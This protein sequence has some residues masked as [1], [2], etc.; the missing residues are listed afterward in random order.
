MEAINGTAVRHQNP[1][2]AKAL[3]DLETM[4]ANRRSRI[5][6]FEAHPITK[7]LDAII[8]RN[9]CPAPRGGMDGA[10]DV[11]ANAMS[12]ENAKRKA[13]EYLRLSRDC[14]PKGKAQFLRRAASARA[15]AARM[16][17]AE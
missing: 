4:E 12:A 6:A 13:A 7:R 9:T 17:T 10:S 3:A 11:I 16:V 15:Y 8:E 5:A 2:M 14:K 1:A